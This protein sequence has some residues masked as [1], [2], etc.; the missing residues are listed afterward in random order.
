MNY[1]ELSMS[2]YD[3]MKLA[4]EEEKFM[5]EHGNKKKEKEKEKFNWREW[6]IEKIEN[7]FSSLRSLIDINEKEICGQVKKI[8]NEIDDAIKKKNSL[9]DK[10]EHAS[11][12]EKYDTTIYDEITIY[13]QKISNKRKEIDRVSEL[14]KYVYQSIVLTA[15]S[16]LEN[17]INKYCRDCQKLFN[18][19][20]KLT[21]L[22]HNGVFRATTYLDKV[23]QMESEILGN[24]R[25]GKI[26]IINELRNDLMHYNGD[27]SVKREEMSSGEKS[28]KKAKDKYEKEF[29]VRCSNNEITITCNSALLIISQIEDFF[30]FVLRLGCKDKRRSFLKGAS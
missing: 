13:E 19:S 2:S 6:S 3:E 4:I 17:E 24:H 8:E 26:K 1:E 18:L 7:N 14:D 27:L 10:M 16:I 11:Y 15:Y 23:V 5:E 28:I 30:K 22:N 20:I 25:W 29:K 12:D 9:E 21:D